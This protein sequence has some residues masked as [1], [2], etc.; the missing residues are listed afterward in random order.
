MSWWLEIA[1]S[2]CEQ[3]RVAAEKRQQCLTKPPG[4]LGRLETL[5]VDFAAWQRTPQPL[6]DDIVVRVFA[7]DHGVAL[8]GVSAFPQAV[9]ASML[10]NF[11]AGGAAICVLARQHGANFSVVNVGVYGATSRVGVIDRVL[12][13]GSE[14]LCRRPAMSEAIVVRAL[15]VGAEQITAASHLFIGG[16][17]GIGNTTSAAALT[18]AFLE[19]PAMSTVGPGTGINS[20]QLRHKVAVVERALATHGAHLKSPLE[21]L[22]RLGGLEIA[23][24]C[25]AYI[26]CAQRGVPALI[27]GYIS[28]AAALAAC[29]INASVRQ[30]LLFAH[31]SSEPG[32]QHLLR[33]LSAK[34]LLDF[35]LRLGE[36]SGAALVLPLLQSACLLHRQMATFASAGITMDEK[37]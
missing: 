33:E 22:R 3:S 5:A 24:L 36:G 13:E 30:W 32:Q 31:R 15:E 6:L 9:T 28:T 7:A 23:A 1:Q 11:A 4:S 35:E 19:L 37:I 34:P 25:G 8:E 17:M 16:E 21:I 14:N 2:P 26:A 20:A 27:D 12:A 10:K 29:R 18:C